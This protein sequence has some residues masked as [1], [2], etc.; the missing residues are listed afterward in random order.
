MRRYSL[1]NPPNGAGG[2]YKWNSCRVDCC[3]Q[4]Q[5][6]HYLPATSYHSGG[7]NVTMADGSVRFIKDS[8]ANK[9]WF[10]LIVSNDTWIV[11]SDQY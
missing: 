5:A 3:Q 7:V 6:A 10:S 8:I 9:T 2:Q 4:A 11:S 1:R